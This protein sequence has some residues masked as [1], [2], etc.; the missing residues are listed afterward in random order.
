MD[1]VS[2]FRPRALVALL[3]AFLLVTPAAFAQGTSAAP[4]APAAAQNATPRVSADVFQKLRP[5]AFRI[6]QRAANATTAPDGLGTGFF[7]SKDGLALTAYHVV[8]GAKELS[9]RLVGSDKRV[10]V[11]VIGFDDYNDIALLRVKVTE[12]VPFLPLAQNGPKVGDAALAIGNGGGSFLRDKYGTFE[13]LDVA[14]ERADFPS[15]T[16]ELNAQLIPGDSGGPIINAR[17][18][19]VGVVSYIQVGGSSSGG[20]NLRIKSYAIPVTQSSKLVADLRGGVKRDAPVLGVS[21]GG[22]IGNVAGALDDADELFPS[23]GLGS[24]LGVTFSGVQD[25]SPAAKAGLKPLV[26][27]DQG[28][29]QQ[30]RYPQFSGD[31]IVAIDGKAV[32]AWNDLVSQIRGKKIGDAIKLTVARGTQTVEVSVTLAARAEIYGSR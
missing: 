7:I 4:S 16:L 31:V 22:Q 14:S 3:S 11:E 5:T 13:R 30:N 24:K 25:G 28:S 19:A 23:I 9:A 17:G 8:F 10:P 20:S 1:S 18:E 27:V 6:E 21:R 26:L 12:D 2:H 32:R 15:G 29:Q